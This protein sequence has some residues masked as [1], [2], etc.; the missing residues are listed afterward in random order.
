MPMRRL[1]LLR[2]AKAERPRGVADHERP[3]SRRGRQSSLL[4]GRYMAEENLVPD[5]AVVSTALRTRETWELAAA[6]FW[7]AVPRRDE[8]RLYDAPAETILDLVRETEAAVETL[9]VVGHNPGFH[10]LALLLAAEAPERLAEKFP[11]G[12]LAVLEFVAGDWRAIAAGE[13]RVERFVTPAS[14]AAHGV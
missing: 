7:E 14:I 4:V 8:P 10:A 2:H 3:L 13:G 9:A 11:T 1:M 12:A 5:L 6:G